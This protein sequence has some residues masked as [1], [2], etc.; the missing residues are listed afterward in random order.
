MLQ[1]SH[2]SP[3]MERTQKSHGHAVIGI[4]IIFALIETNGIRLHKPNRTPRFQSDL[5]DMK[6][7]LGLGK[8]S[9][10]DEVHRVLFSKLDSWLRPSEVTGFFF[11]HHFCLQ[12]LYTIV[13]QSF[14]ILKAGLGS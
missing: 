8:S 9:T 13:H 2:T 12:I 5:E 7:D 1:P 14:L 4:C 3:P 6:L 10:A 11:G